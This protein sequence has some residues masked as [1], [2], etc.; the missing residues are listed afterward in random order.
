MIMRTFIRKTLIGLGAAVLAIVPLTA[1]AQAAAPAAPAGL[2]TVSPG[3]SV[4]V[5]ARV[6]V[7]PGMQLELSIT[8]GNYS[9]TPSLAQVRFRIY[10]ITAD[11]DSVN[12]YSDPQVVT[13]PG[14]PGGEPKGLEDLKEVTADMTVP[15][16]CAAQPDDW[17]ISQDGEFTAEMGPPGLEPTGVKSSLFWIGLPFTNANKIPNLTLQTHG[18]QAESQAHHTLPQ[19][20]ETQFNA[21]GIP[22]IHDP[23]Y[24]R[25]WCSR[26][27]VP[28]NHQSMAYDY[29]L[30]WQTFFEQNPAPT[31]A[32]V[33]A[34]KDSIQGLY[35]YTCP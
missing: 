2:Y 4:D 23:I 27:G 12:V 6:V 13:V 16:E 14:D 7:L 8:L 22:N 31:A 3:S 30:H 34:Y 29:N 35:T 19:K 15:P 10:C 25:W 11:L 32:Q 24:L 5:N 33:L 26:T 20:F 17:G 1:H 9:A 21:A 28:G 18:A